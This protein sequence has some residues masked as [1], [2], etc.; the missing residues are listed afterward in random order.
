MKVLIVVGGILKKSLVILLLLLTISLISPSHVVVG[1]PYAKLTYYISV[2]ENANATI[3][4]VFEASGSGNGFIG[5]PLFEK[6]KVTVYEGNVEWL[7]FRNI[8]VFYTNASFSFSGE[9]VRIEI[10]YDFPYATLIAEDKAWIMSPYI[11][12][13]RYF[14]V[15]VEVE[16][17]GMNPLKPVRFWPYEPIKREENR[18]TFAILNP[19]MDNRVIIE[20]ELWERVQSTPYTRNIGNSEVVVRVAKYYKHIA[21]KVFYVLEKTYDDLEYVFGELPEKLEFEFYLPELND[22]SALGYVKERVIE[23]GVE[24][25]I[26]LN[27]ALIRFKEGFLEETV[28]HECVHVALGLIGVSS[29]REVR[30]FHEGMAEYVAIKVCGKAGINVTDFIELHK[31]GIREALRLFNG[32][33]SFIINWEYDT[34]IARLYYSAAFYI[35]NVTAEEN[36]GLPYVRKLVEEIEVRGG[37]ENNEDIISAMSQAAGKDLGPQFKNW[38]FPVKTT[39]KEKKD[40]NSHEERDLVRKA[41]SFVKAILVIVVAVITII[42]AILGF[43]VYW[44]IV[45][46]KRIFYHSP[47]YFIIRPK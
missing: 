17:Y 12:A 14:D 33:L 27:L 40:S 36:G 29:S 13:P 42:I 2:R 22:L 34:P 1:Q 16:L 23:M 19:L 38:G 26:Y 7:S 44:F 41:W 10:T 43:L 8:S 31:A 4:L 28:V 25:P 18:F 5:L 35:I 20:Y 47:V 3:S 37:I 9:K 21:D 46:R 45:R 30:W 15:Y 11:L 24:G 32:D 6:Y 39:E